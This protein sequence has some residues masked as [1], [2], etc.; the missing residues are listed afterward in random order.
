MAFKS[1]TCTITNSI[2]NSIHPKGN[3]SN[4]KKRVMLLIKS[5]SIVHSSINYITFSSILDPTLKM[6]QFKCNVIPSMK[7]KVINSIDW[8]ENSSLEDHYTVYLSFDLLT[9]EILSYAHSICGC[10][11]GRHKFSHM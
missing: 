4:R 6:I 3:E 1:A 9:K 11:D 10:Y 2:I 5:G 7:S 8:N